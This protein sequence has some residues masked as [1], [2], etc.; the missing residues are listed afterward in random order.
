[1]NQKIYGDVQWTGKPEID[2]LLAKK[3][4][5]KAARPKQLLDM[6]RDIHTYLLLSGR[7]FG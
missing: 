6:R 5:L 7:G 2:S 1:M 4:W 3:A